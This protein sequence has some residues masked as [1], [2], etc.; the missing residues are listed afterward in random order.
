M[1]NG[2]WQRQV[3]LVVLCHLLDIVL[4][5]VCSNKNNYYLNSS[6]K[7]LSGHCHPLSL[8]SWKS[9]V[10]LYFSAGELHLIAQWQTSTTS[11][12]YPSNIFFV[13]K[14][15]SLFAII[16]PFKSTLI[17]VP[18]PPVCRWIDSL[19]MDAMELPKTIVQFEITRNWLLFCIGKERHNNNPRGAAKSYCHDD[20][21]RPDYQRPWTQ[22]GGEVTDQGLG[23]LLFDTQS[24][25]LL[26]CLQSTLKSAKYIYRLHYQPKFK[27]VL[28]RTG[29]WA[30]SEIEQKKLTKMI[31]Y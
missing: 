23:H 30:K 12:G 2:L 10:Q 24:N 29:I 17:R 20:Y 3:I 21:M 25:E 5:R 14:I 11:G 6:N 4:D 1:V 16:S 8:N 9:S 31:G 13:D 18:F 19:L 26:I 28:P 15:H 27:S 22:T 7:I